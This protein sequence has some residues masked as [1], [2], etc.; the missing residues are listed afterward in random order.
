MVEVK[1]VVKH[2]RFNTERLVEIQKPDSYK[3]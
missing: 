3:K 1:F 2:Q